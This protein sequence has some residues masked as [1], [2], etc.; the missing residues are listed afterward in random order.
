MKVHA[1]I[2]KLCKTQEKRER[3]KWFYARHIF[4]EYEETSLSD[5]LALAR[6]CEHED[7]R[8]LVSLFPKGAPA[9]KSEAA[10]VFLAQG[11]DARCL[12]WAA[13]CGAE[14]KEGLL[15]LSA[16]GGYGWGQRK[17][18]WR[19]RS[20]ERTMWLE[21]AVARVEPSAM[22]EFAHH[23]RKGQDVAVDGARADDMLR[24]A[25]ELGDSF[26]QYQFAE[27][28]CAEDSLEHYQ[29]LRRSAVQRC[30]SALYSMVCDVVEQ[31]HLYD[32]G[33]SGRIMFEFGEAFAGIGKWRYDGYDTEKIAAGMRAVKLYEQ[34]CAEAKR[35]VLCWISLARDLVVAK[36]IRLMIADLIWD[37]RAAWSERVVAADL[38]KGMRLTGVN[39]A[40]QA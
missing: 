6:Q 27:H 30:K 3:I 12:C 4:F 9:T 7:A 19:V 2:L 15:R 5:G 35:A 22:P 13:C 37:Q 23:L 34:W 18:A 11:G 25:A 14:P 31:L 38:A 33:A 28:C 26:A 17:H 24:E 32:S 39:A 40:L 10:A 20:E 29:W 8:F 16:E 1:D 21:K 36:D